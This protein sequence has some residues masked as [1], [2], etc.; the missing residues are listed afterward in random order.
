VSELKVNVITKDIE[1]K[2]YTDD[3]IKN[4]KGEKL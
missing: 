4:I 3:T 1:E 2:I